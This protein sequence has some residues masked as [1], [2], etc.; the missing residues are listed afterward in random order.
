MAAN[1]QLVQTYGTKLKTIFSFP[2]SSLNDKSFKFNP[3][4]LDLKSRPNALNVVLRFR[5]NLALYPNLCATITGSWFL[6]GGIA[7]SSISS[8]YMAIPKSSQS[9]EG[10]A[11]LSYNTRI[12]GYRS[13]DLNY[14][15]FLDSSIFKRRRCPG[16]I[17]IIARP[18]ESKSRYALRSLGFDSNSF[19][20]AITR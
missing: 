18:R 5:V 12:A 13:S 3:S 15:C 6:S 4:S 20:S 17:H 1:P 2:I 9:I 8:P 19:T 16:S 11:T 7:N 10:R 14:S